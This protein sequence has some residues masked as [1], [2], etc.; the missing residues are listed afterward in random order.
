MEPRLDNLVRSRTDAAPDVVGHEEDRQV[1]G[2]VHLVRVQVLLGL[3]RRAG[4]VNLSDEVVER[5]TAVSPEVIGTV[6]LI[7]AQIGVSL[8]LCPSTAPPHQCSLSA[9]RRRRDQRNKL[10]ERH[11]FQ[12]HVDAFLGPG[13]LQIL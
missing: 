9:I 10:G 5:L 7:Q 8:T 1:F 13:G 6:A 11:R 2:H 4:R 12:R 3:R